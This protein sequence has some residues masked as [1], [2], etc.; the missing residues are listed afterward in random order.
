MY[1][2]AA[3]VVYAQQRAT[4]AKPAG[5]PDPGILEAQ[6]YQKLIEKHRGKPVLVNFWATWCEPCR[7]EYP[8]ANEL[9]RVYERQ[10]LVVIGISLD[11]D[12]DIN[13]VRRFIERYKPVFP[14][15][16]KKP[17]KDAE[18]FQYVDAQW[19]GTIPATFFYGRDGKLAARLMGSAPRLEFEKIIQ[20]LLSAP[21]P[22]TRAARRSAP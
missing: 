14:N 5:P 9:A 22:A 19:R 15:Y 12:I 2:M 8:M 21:P 16:R 17:G 18:F 3:C 20:P 6:N 1:L 4:G 7:D 13:L 11:E 10:G